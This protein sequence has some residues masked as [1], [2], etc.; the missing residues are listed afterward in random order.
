MYPVINLLS[1]IELPFINRVENLIYTIFLFA[2]LISLV[3][4]T[5][6]AL[7]SLKQIFPAAKAGILE[8][9]LAVLSFGFG[10]IP[11]IARES[12]RLLILAYYAEIALSFTAPVALLLLLAWQSLFRRKGS[13][14]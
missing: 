7:M 12:E 4:F 5:W 9:A 1:F 10:C 13:M 8:L 3:M 2:N 11:R 14:P 6:A